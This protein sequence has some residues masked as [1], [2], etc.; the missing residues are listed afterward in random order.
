MP[1]QVISAGQAVTPA[2]GSAQLVCGR[3]G[4]LLGFFA[5][6]TGSVVINDAA[7]VAAAG[8]GNQKLNS[9]ACAV[10]WNPFPLE[11]TQGLVVNIAAAVAGTFIFN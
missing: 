7:T 6:A 11:F 9:A 3:S 4:Q 5:A 10:G 2:T 1:N 8:A